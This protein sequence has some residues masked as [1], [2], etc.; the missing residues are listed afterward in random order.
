[1]SVK[2]TSRVWEQ[3]ETKGTDLLVMLAL[4]D[5]ANDVGHS[6]PGVGGHLADKTRLERRAI[7]MRIKALA[8]TGELAVFPRRGSSHDFLIT[9][10]MSLSEIRTAYRVIAKRRGLT[11]S[12]LIRLRRA[13]RYGG[14]E[15]WRNLL[16]AYAGQ[17]KRKARRSDVAARGAE[18]PSPKLGPPSTKSTSNPTPKPLGLPDNER[19]AELADLTPDE[20]Q[21]FA[22]YAEGRFTDAPEPEDL[23]YA[24]EK[25]G[26]HVLTRAISVVDVKPK[27][28]R[29]WAY[30]LGTAQG[31]AREG[32][33][34]NGE[35]V[36]VSVAYG[37]EL[38]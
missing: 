16:R 32:A 37:Q 22:A 36:T 19:P 31:I 30:V 9:L 7:G 35:T 27:H 6:W 4:A 15:D 38:I 3:S 11:V 5:N 21:V 18:T 29:N 33:N 25:F 24:L 2:I 10:G 23:R 12:Q 34:G 13:F 14:V 28:L 20:E 8:Q 1:M 17:A 26:A